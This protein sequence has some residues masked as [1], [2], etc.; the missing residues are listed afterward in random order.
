MEI[1]NCFR[2]LLLLLRARTQTVG[3]SFWN[4]LSLQSFGIGKMCVCYM[5]VTPA[6]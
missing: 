3:T 5:I 6:Y 1:I 4:E 2:M